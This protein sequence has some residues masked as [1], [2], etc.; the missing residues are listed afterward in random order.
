[1]ADKAYPVIDSKKCNGCGTCISTC[2][3]EVFVLEKNKAKVKKPKECIGCRAC[4]SQCPA[5]AIK[6]VE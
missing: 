2:P 4:E 6:I 3:M 1:M 5:Q